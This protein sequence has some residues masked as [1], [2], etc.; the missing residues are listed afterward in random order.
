MSASAYPTD[1][2]ASGQSAPPAN[3]FANLD[4][5]DDLAMQFV[6][7]FGDSYRWTPGMDWMT[8]QPGANCWRRD[9]KLE[10][11]DDARQLA[12][13]ASLRAEKPTERKAY[14][15]AKTVSSIITLARS[16]R[17][18]ALSAD[19]WD[20]D[21]FA[22]NTPDGIV[23]LRTGQVRERRAID[24][25]THCARVAPSPASE[26]PLWDRFLAEV[27]L[28]DRDVIEFVQRMVGYTLTADRSEQL[29]FFC[30]G[31][32]ANAKS[33]F[34]DFILWMLG[35]YAMKLPATV[36]MQSQLQNHPTE[37]AQLHGRRLALSS[38]L[39]EGQYWAEARIKELTG[40][41]ILRARF[42]RQDFFE[43][44]MTQK[45]VIVGNFK[46]RLK[47]GDHALAR[48]FVLVPFRAKFAAGKR[49]PNMLAKLRAEAPAVLRWAIE[50]A[51]KWR[52]EGLAIPAAV[53]AASSAYMAEN[54]DLLLWADERCFMHAGA[55]SK[56][57]LLYDDY[58]KWLRSR[59]QQAPSM[60]LWGERMAAIDGVTK[61]KS[62][63]L[64]VYAGIGL[65][66]VE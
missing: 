45:H 65:R 56:S 17:N 57:S 23:D 40:D 30:Y 43:F 11:F 24:Y 63:G 1:R 8:C 27:F 7:T 31:L 62:D 38:E 42:M 15:S 53:V 58:V 39:E 41:E 37:L 26:C 54:D 46:P 49:D 28:G 14:A 5:E 2:K 36:L 21:G 55:R 20:A 16:D 25:V 44:P 60:K 51:V 33:T 29:L 48:R 4:T 50:G 47:G 12:R 3:D 52:T 64:M 34:W 9:D 6:A 22:L 19:A 10:R 35:S 59:G 61:R 32:G 66:T 18:I 13:V